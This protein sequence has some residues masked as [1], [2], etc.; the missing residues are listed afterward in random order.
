MDRG[1][2]CESPRLVGQI[3]RPTRSKLRQHTNFIDTE[4]LLAQAMMGKVPGCL[5]SF[6][7]SNTDPS[8]VESDPRLFQ[9]DPRQG[10]HL[11]AR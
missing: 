7:C 9:A 4:V 1:G 10:M 6:H 11:H 3:W 5:P 2:R 8:P